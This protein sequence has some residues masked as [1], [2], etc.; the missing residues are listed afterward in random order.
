LMAVIRIRSSSDSVK[1]SL[2]QVLWS[3]SRAR[4]SRLLISGRNLALR[5]LTCDASPIHTRQSRSAKPAGDV[6]KDDSTLQTANNFM[7]FLPNRR[8][9]TEGTI[10]RTAGHC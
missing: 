3:S 10:V 8:R 9:H 7:H 2:V 5:R 4:A 1:S 6:G